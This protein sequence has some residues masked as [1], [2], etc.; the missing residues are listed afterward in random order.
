MSGNVPAQWTERGRMREEMG[1]ENRCHD[2]NDFLGKFW[3]FQRTVKTDY[4]MSLYLS[5][6]GLILLTVRLR[7]VA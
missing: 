2:T 3:T 1:D 6:Y 4:V 5:L 7:H